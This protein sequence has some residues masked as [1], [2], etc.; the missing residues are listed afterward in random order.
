MSSGYQSQYI[1]TGHRLSDSINSKL[2]LDVNRTRA[3]PPISV[4]LKLLYV[5][6][7]ETTFVSDVCHGR[8]V[9]VT[10]VRLYP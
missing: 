6:I 8:Y 5:V 3:A 9:Q 2:K 7:L 10:L 4:I 1:Q